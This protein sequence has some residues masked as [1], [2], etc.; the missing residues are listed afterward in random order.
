MCSILGGTAFDKKA[1]DIYEKA[2][3]RGRDFSGLCQRHG[4]WIANH[5]ATPTTEVATPIHNQ[6]LGGEVKIVHNGVI[7]NDADLG[8]KDGEID[9]SI[10]ADVLDFSDLHKF[11][12]SLA[13]VKGSYAIAALKED[14]IYLACNYKPIWVLH[15]NGQI[16]FSS[17]KH[18]LG[19]DARRMPPY[20]VMDLL[21]GETLEIPRYQSKRAVV[22]C[23]GGLDSTAVAAYACHVHGASNV[24]LLHFR[25][26]CNAESAEVKRIPLIAQRL[27]CNYH[28]FTL[29]YSDMAG[30]SPI[31]DKKK[32]ASV[33]EGITGAEYA[34][35][36]VPARNFVFM[37]LT[38]AYAEANDYG[39]IYLGTNLE[40]GGAYPDN[41]EQ[42]ILDV[43]NCLYGAVQNGKKIEIHTPLG[44]LMKREIVEFGT[45]YN[46]P[47]DLSWSCYRNG[48]KHCGHCGPCFMR[49][50]AFKRAGIPDPTEYEE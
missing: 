44:G 48:E 50:T 3:D 40:E 1:L 41:E 19:E 17:L 22:I 7:A 4:L 30:S 46:A 24:M 9:S 34:Y 36:W 6:P 33:S 29:P 20:S 12:D 26:G 10:L 18:H 21:T 42:F 43:N 25:Y 23:S 39:H 2:K 15:E 47:F 37:A 5:R 27:G 35:E 8:V 28:F 49:K 11:R 13:K 16:Y 31:M 32:D 14:T 45:K 38:T